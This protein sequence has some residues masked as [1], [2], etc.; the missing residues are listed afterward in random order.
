M[1]L[2]ATATEL[3]R[4]SALLPTTERAAFR[5]ALEDLVLEAQEQA[6]RGVAHVLVGAEP[7][8]FGDAISELDPLDYSTQAEYGIDAAAA[9]VIAAAD[10]RAGGL[11]TTRRRKLTAS[12]LP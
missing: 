9:Y 1:A 6:L 4:I 12:L 2:T 5:A 10:K 7:Q 8:H 11:T 3:A